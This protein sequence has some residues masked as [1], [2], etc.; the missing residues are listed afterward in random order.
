MDPVG[1]AI[2]GGGIFV[3]EQ[4]IPAALASP[5]L[6][7]KAIWSRSLK[8]AEDAAKLVPA[9]AGPVDLYSSDAGAGKSYEDILKRDDI[10]GVILALPIVDQPAYIEKALAAGKHVLAEKPLAKDVATALALIEYYKRV[11]AET[12]ASFAVAENFRFTPSYL[13]A[14]EEV[15]KLGKVTGFVV[16]VSFMMEQSNK[17]FKTWR[18]KPA[19]Q[20]GFLL[21][22][23]VHFTA[24]LRKLLGADNAVDSLVAHTAL[25]SEHLPPVDTIHA[26]LKTESGVVGSFVNCVGSTM[27]AFEFTVACEQGVVKAESAK[28]IT[29]RGFG[30]DA[31]AEEKAFEPT[32]GVQEEVQ[33]WAE[34]ILSG[35]PNPSQTPELA[36]GDLELLEKMLTSGDQDGAS[37]KLQ[38]QHF[39]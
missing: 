24:A 16:R 21:D 15:K 27:G 14:A 30:K 9:D 22:A 34:S 6:S 28:V 23:G 11:S 12:A 37:Q 7:I 25:A 8:T 35:V 26:V 38:Y 4:H 10:T 32:T 13:Y 3:K 17:Y 20:G 39:V 36:L 5:L 18:I 19:Y 1:I 29:T 2:I 31:V 33:A